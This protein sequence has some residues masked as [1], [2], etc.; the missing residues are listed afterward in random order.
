MYRYELWILNG[1]LSIHPSTILSFLQGNQR[2]PFFFEWDVKCI[3]QKAVSICSSHAAVWPQLCF[4]PTAEPPFYS[5]HL[6]LQI[7]ES[8][9]SK[10]NKISSYQ[11]L[12]HLKVWIF[13]SFSS[14]MP[15]AVIQW[16]GSTSW[17]RTIFVSNCRYASWQRRPCSKPS[18]WMQN[19]QDTLQTLHINFGNANTRTHQEALW[20]LWK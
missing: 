2:E 15:I 6:T 3:P 8:F 12:N 11:I 19:P 18:K 4:V 7:L 9:I 5:N 20:A 16:L 14:S 13:D 17:N 1:Y 10:V